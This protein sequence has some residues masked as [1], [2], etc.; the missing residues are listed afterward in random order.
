MFGLA[1]D[2][3]G[4][5]YNSCWLVMHAGRRSME[6]FIV[7]TFYK[8]S[9]QCLRVFKFSLSLDFSYELPLNLKFKGIVKF[10][11]F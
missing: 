8:Y 3:Q 11:K 5:A 2:F 9:V 10:L 6:D 1:Q 7:D 4:Y